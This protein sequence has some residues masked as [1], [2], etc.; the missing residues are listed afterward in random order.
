MPAGPGRENS[1]PYLVTNDAHKAEIYKYLWML[2]T[3]GDQGVFAEILDTFH[4][5]WETR[6][7]KFIAYFRN[8]YASRVGQL[9]YNRSI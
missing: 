2:M 1:T 4:Q 7:P 8:N 5:F 3:E 9:Y 6:E